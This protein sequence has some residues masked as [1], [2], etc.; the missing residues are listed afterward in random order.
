VHWVGNENTSVLPHQSMVPPSFQDGYYP[1][2]QPDTMCLANFRLSLRDEDGGRGRSIFEPA[3]LSAP[4]QA[5]P[6]FGG[7]GDEGKG[8]LDLE[9]PFGGLVAEEAHAEQAAGPAA[10]GAEEAEKGFRHA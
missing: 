7:E 2:S 6:D 4:V 9:G 8:V 10:D 5:G 3:E 1:I